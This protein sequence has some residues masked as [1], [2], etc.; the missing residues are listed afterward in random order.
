MAYNEQLAHKLRCLLL[1][2]AADLEE[3]KMMGGLIFMLHGKMCCGIDKD[4]LMVRVVPEKYEACL[5]KKDC[6]V[7]DMTGKVL[8]NFLFISRAGYR[9]DNDLKSWL[10]LGVEFVMRQK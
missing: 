10:E 4:R 5:R 2:H 7:M 9:Q 3:R 1:P 8:K 6:H